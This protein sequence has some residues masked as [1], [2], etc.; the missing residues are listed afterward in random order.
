MLGHTSS[1]A[2]PGCQGAF[3]SHP[4]EIIPFFRRFR[5]GFMRNIVYTVIWNSLFALFFTLLSVI[6]DREASIATEFRITFVMAQC[7][8]FIIYAMFL[9]GDRVVPGIHRAGWWARAAYYSVIPAI[10]IFPGYLLAFWILDWPQGANWLFSSRAVVSIAAV[11]LVLTGLML[12]IFIPRERAVRAEAAVANEQARVAAAEKEA[13]MARMKLLEAQVEPHFLYNTLAH[14][15]SLI[16]ADP[17]TAKRM[18]ERLI[19]LLRSSASSAA[20]TGTLGTQI[21]LLRAYLEI[22]E[23]RMGPR[24]RWRID[25]PASLN[26]VEVPPMLLQPVVE[27]AVKHGLEPALGTVE[28]AIDARRSGPALVLTVTDTGR[29]F[30]ETAPPSA[31]G[32]GL[33]NLRARL[34]AAYGDAAS[35]TIE[36]VRPHGARVTLAMPIAS[37]PIVIVQPGGRDRVAIP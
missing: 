6:F 3:T 4:L 10:A 28:I 14:V 32:I 2:P 9:I 36:D 23:L 1:I 11:S 22:I 12:L 18:I 17:G 33:A 15:V 31:S 13:T 29:G 8:G 19:A 35:V 20:G 37:G 25:A 7:I 5:P 26:G 27:N 34:A 24:L 16:D 30:R 21:A